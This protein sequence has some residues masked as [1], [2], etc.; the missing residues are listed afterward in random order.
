MKYFEWPKENPTGKIKYTSSI[1][2]VPTELELDLSTVS[3]KWDDMLDS[4]TAAAPGTEAQQMAVAELMRAVGY[5]VDMNYGTAASGGS[6]AQ[7][8]KV[9]DAIVNNFGYDKSV[10]Y[11]QRDCY[12]L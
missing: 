6:G 3:L 4:Y 2:G 9:S 12:T 1:D 5:A 11:L 10:E 7:T 8:I